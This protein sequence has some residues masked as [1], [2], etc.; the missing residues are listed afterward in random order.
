MKKSTLI[1]L[2]LTDQFLGQGQTRQ[3]TIHKGFQFIDSLF[4][5]GTHEFRIVDYVYSDSIQNLA[6]K[7]DSS[8]SRNKDW[9][10]EYT[11]KYYKSG[12]GMPYD[13]HMGISR[14]QYEL[15]LHLDTAQSTLK[16]L[17]SG[18]VEIDK[19]VGIITF[20]MRNENHILDYLVINIH[21]SQILFEN[22]SIPFSEEMVVNNIQRMG[23]WQGYAW[24][25]EEVDNP[26]PAKLTDITSKLIN[27]IFATTRS[28]QLFIRLKFQAVLMGKPIANEDLLFF[29]D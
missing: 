7:M 6:I 8:V 10:L 26:D 15:F 29:I 2:L 28:G 11:K 20:R 3:D 22:D 18:Q 5:G 24:N 27:L 23:P 14:S 19:S 21:T 4:T 9:F 16:V 12:E 17:Q 1:V 25:K 13:P